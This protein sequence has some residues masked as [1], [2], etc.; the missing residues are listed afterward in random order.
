MIIES[1]SGLL[2]TVPDA[3]Y[4]ELL[5]RASSV[6]AVRASILSQAGR[7]HKHRQQL[8]RYAAQTLTPEEQQAV[9]CLAR[10]LV[11]Q[12]H[13]DLEM[14]RLGYGNYLTR[15][16][17]GGLLPESYSRIRERA[18]ESAGTPPDTL[19]DRDRIAAMRQLGYL[20]VDDADYSERIISG[21][22]WE[23]WAPIGWDREAIETHSIGAA[24]A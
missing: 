2:V 22:T 10:A 20:T 23:I 9:E 8:I 21:S 18:V 5:L 19:H 12:A 3:E 17:R 6:E 24:I 15:R 13:V 7:I 11:R 16:D 14:I 1:K 4:G